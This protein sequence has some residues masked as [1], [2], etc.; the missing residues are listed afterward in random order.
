MY[1]L[2]SVDFIYSFHLSKIAFK[3]LG[4]ETLRSN[5]LNYSGSVKYFLASF[6][7]YSPPYIDN[8]LFFLVQI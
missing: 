2:D 6:S 5:Q 3:V 4:I 1:N 7:I 8:K